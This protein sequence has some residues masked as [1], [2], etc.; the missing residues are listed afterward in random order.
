MRYLAHKINLIITL[1]TIL[2]FEKKNT[3]YGK[4]SYCSEIIN[5]GDN[6]FFYCSKFAVGAG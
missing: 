2:E 6:D 4:V 3:A 5:K 1:L